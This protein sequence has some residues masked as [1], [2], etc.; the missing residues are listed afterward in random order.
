MGN[1]KHFIKVFFTDDDEGYV[2]NLDG[3]VT[4]VA[5]SDEQLHKEIGKD[6]HGE[7]K[8]A[9]DREDDAVYAY[10]VDY[11]ITPIRTDPFN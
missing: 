2:L 10:R 1:K 6:I 9:L 7:I 11:T 3:S 4:C 8:E 5:A